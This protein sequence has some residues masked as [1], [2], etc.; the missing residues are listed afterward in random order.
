VPPT[1][2]FEKIAYFLF[3]LT[4]LVLFIDLLVRIVRGMIGW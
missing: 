4:L 1:D 2:P 3:R